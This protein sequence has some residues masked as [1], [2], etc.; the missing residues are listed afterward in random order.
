MLRKMKK[1]KIWL[2]VITLG[3][4]SV[5]NLNKQTLI[6]DKVMINESELA[7]Q[8]SVFKKKNLKGENTSN[9]TILF[10]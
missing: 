7:K 8:L 9:Q 3:M 2:E 5:A 1:W 4:K 10:Y 6:S